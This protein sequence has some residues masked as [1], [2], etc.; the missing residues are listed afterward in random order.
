MTRVYCFSGIIKISLFRANFTIFF[1]LRPLWLVIK[2]WFGLCWLH[3]NRLYWRFLFHVFSSLVIERWHVLCN[4]EILCNLFNEFTLIKWRKNYS[5]RS[6]WWKCF[7]SR[8]LSVIAMPVLVNGLMEINIYF[9]MSSCSDVI[10]IM[11][12]IIMKTKKVSL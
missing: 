3:M 1:Y 5:I 10:T 8:V 7:E 12:I 6:E 11:I 4:S 2:Q 9:C